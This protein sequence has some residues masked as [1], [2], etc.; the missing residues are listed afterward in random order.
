MDTLGLAAFSDA[1]EAAASVWQ[2]K[3]SLY[4]EGVFPDGL[5]QLLNGGLSEWSHLPP[6]AA[7]A[8]GSP[9]AAATAPGGW[10]LP[11]VRR[12]LLELLRRRLLVADEHPTLSRF[13]TFREHV[14]GLLL[15]V[16][17]GIGKKMFVFGSV[18]PV[19]K[20][21]K[22]MRSVLA[23]LDHPLTDQFL[24]RTSLALRTL[25]H[26]RKTCAQLTSSGEPLL[27]RILSRHCVDCISTK[28][29]TWRP[30]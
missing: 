14:D 18:R 13:F 1:R 29:W 19:D 16:F 11:A 12:R 28:I 3:S 22:R 6:A 20:T 8:P 26:V 27:V 4:R 9:F 21:S 15:I 7:A 24:R 10:S 30:Q 17:L 5:L 25:D 2:R 23:F